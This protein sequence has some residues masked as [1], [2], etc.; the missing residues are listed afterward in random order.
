[1]EKLDRIEEVYKEEDDIPEV[2]HE[3]LEKQRQ[4][5]KELKEKTGKDVVSPLEIE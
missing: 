5:L 4:R 1:L 3:H 2:F